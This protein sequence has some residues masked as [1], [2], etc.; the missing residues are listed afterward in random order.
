MADLVNIQR[1][2]SD[3]GKPIIRI[4]AFSDCFDNMTGEYYG[5]NLNYKKTLNLKGFIK[6]VPREV[7]RT[8]SFNCRTQKVR[9]SRV[10][11]IQGAD[12]YHE[13]K[14]NEIEDMLSLKT[15]TIDGE[16]V[17]YNGGVS[18]EEAN[19][20]CPKL[21]RLRLQVEECA[22]QQIHGCGDECPTK[23]NIFVIPERQI[24]DTYFDSQGRR[25]ASSFQGLINWF[26][27]QSGITVAEEV[28]ALVDCLY[29]KVLRVQGTGLVPSTIYFDQPLAQ[30]K[31]VAY[32]IDLNSPDINLICNGVNNNECGVL[33]L[34]APTI[35]EVVCDDITLG[36]PLIYKIGE[37]CSIVPMGSWYEDG[38]NEIAST[39]IHKNMTLKL[40]SDAHIL[41]PPPSSGTTFS[42]TS[43]IQSN[44]T[45]QTDIADDAVIQE[46]RRN[47]VVQ[48][49]GQYSY[50]PTTKVI[51]LTNCLNTNDT[52]EIDYS[53]TSYP[54][55]SEVIARITGT[56]CTPNS[57]YVFNNSTNSSIPLGAN[58]TLYS[59]GEIKWTGKVTQAD[60]SGSTIEIDN[61]LYTSIG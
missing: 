1:P 4:E 56:M 59:N 19:T 25:I 31:V 45:I 21:Y 34:D 29:Y 28:A 10:Y 37:N 55:I 35:Y 42:Y 15:I 11:E 27:A 52:V 36:T 57:L 60:G 12:L 51:T 47:G 7:E 14:K 24:N 44:C 20:S 6:S 43:S 53:F 41:P 39:G 26:K 9:S 18:F 54:V 8:I 5:G 50:N 49:G 2:T 22:K 48:T 38:T 58:L 32:K 16:E 23:D 30:N 3:C 33:L 46:V 40:R 13:W 17:V 61:I